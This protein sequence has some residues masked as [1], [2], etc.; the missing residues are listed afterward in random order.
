MPVF[1]GH[2]CARLAINPHGQP[3]DSLPVPDHGVVL[4][5]LAI[6]L[7]SSD[8]CS[9]NSAPGNGVGTRVEEKN[10]G[11]PPRQGRAAAR[12]RHEFWQVAQGLAGGTREPGTGA[13]DG[14]AQ[15]GHQHERGQ[16]HRLE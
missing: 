10:Y 2:N 4:I 8:M 13:G 3:T 7:T 6:V 15:Q 11:D 5:M 1:Y 14:R 12:H 16:P 9:R